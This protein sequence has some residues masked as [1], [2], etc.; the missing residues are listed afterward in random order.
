M[1]KCL[2]T[3]LDLF[4]NIFSLFAQW[5]ARIFNTKQSESMKLQIYKNIDI[6][7]VN[8]KTGDTELFFPKNV[9]WADKVVNKIVLYAA[10]T[11]DVE[12]SPIDENDVMPYEHLK[13]VFLNIYSANEEEIIASVNATN[14]IY[15]NNHL[16]EINEKISLKLST[17]KFSK[18]A[19]FDGVLLFYLF[20]DT[21]EKECIDRPKKSVTSEFI[22]NPQSYLPLDRYIDTYIHS[23][24]EKLKGFY[25]WVGDVETPGD[26]NSLYITLRDYNNKTIINS[27]PLRMCRA[28]ILPKKNIYEDPIKA[29]QCQI[30]PIYLD[31]ENIDFAN[32]FIF[33]ADPSIVGEVKI[34][35][36]Y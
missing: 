30:N 32:S 24:G 28:M 14:F 29:H 12:R 27:L 21:K 33:N 8:Y 17:I 5:F 19:E 3:I 20:W 18:P 7:Q 6:L 34:T 16:L 1:K 31:D 13:N 10:P 25:A 36:L 11:F 2:Q 15:T 9:S 22:V 35:F 4:A 23:Q 26:G